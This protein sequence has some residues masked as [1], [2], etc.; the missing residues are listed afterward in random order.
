MKDKTTAGI[1]ALFLGNIGVHRF[2]LGQTGRGILHVLFCWTF[3]PWLIG[4]IDGIVFLTQDKENFDIKYN[5]KYLQRQ[6]VQNPNIIINNHLG[7]PPTQTVPSPPAAAAV[8]EQATVPAGPKL[9]PFRISADKKFED[10][11]FDGAIQDYRRSLNVNPRQAEVHFNLSRLYSIHEQRD[12]ALFHLNQAIENGYYD[13]DEIERHDHLAFLRATPE[14]YAFKSN[15]YRLPGVTAPPNPTVTTTPPA[16]P[17]TPAAPEETLELSD[18]L[19]TRIERLAK[20]KEDGILN[21]DSFA[22]EKAK[23]LRQG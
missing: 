19:I 13:F 16:T 6:S 4:V 7:V 1:L 2:Y 14:F 21:E 8:R 3:I 5:W 10:Y 18:D 23:V 22:R 11:D 20:L 15:S 9:D 17:A 12:T